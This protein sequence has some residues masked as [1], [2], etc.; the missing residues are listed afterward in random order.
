VQGIDPRLAHYGALVGSP[1]TRDGGDLDGVMPGYSAADLL[2]LSNPPLEIIQ[3]L[4]GLGMGKLGS[5]LLE[6]RLK[7]LFKT[8]C[9]PFLLVTFLRLD[10]HS[11]LLFPLYRRGIKVDQS[12]A[13][14]RNGGR[15]TR[16][17]KHPLTFPGHNQIKIA[18]VPKPGQGP[19][20]DR[21]SLDLP[22]VNR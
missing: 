17:L 13:R 20:S 22:L 6:G 18:V 3:L 19:A 15:N 1:V 2:Q 5:N 9:N 12:L 16:L 8:P 4:A 14:T 7:S 21:R 10:M 11:V